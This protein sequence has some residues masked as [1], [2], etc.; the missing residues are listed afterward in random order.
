M[1]DHDSE[2][3]FLP[4]ELQSL[5]PYLR[6]N[7]AG[8]NGQAGTFFIRLSIAYNKVLASR[9]YEIG[10]KTRNLVTALK[11]AGELVSLCFFCGMEITSKRVNAPALASLFP[12]SD[13]SD[14]LG[15][16][17]EEEEAVFTGGNA[18]LPFFIRWAS[19]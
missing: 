1:H 7:S 19:D 12:L 14:D 13:L 11:R 9:R 10:L 3:D 6:I 4:Q 16:D 17:R 5:K 2:L 18:G 8:K 15:R